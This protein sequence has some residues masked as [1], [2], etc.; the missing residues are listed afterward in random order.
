MIRDI[1]KDIVG[2]HE[3]AD[4]IILLLSRRGYR[5]HPKEPT[6]E[7]LEAG[8][9]YRISTDIGQSNTWEADTATLY[10]IMTELAPK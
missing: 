9:Q 1:L 2:S 8:A 3:L 4:K 5:I 7:M 10:I 6:T